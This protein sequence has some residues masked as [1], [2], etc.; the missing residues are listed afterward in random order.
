MSRALVLGGGG[1]TGVAWEL[2]LLAGL[3]ERGVPVTGADLVVGTSAGS[4]VGAQ[5]CSVLPLE[6]FYEEQLVP[7]SSEVAARLGFA[8]LA[9]LVWAGG[10][11]RDV[12]RSRA[13]IGAM[14]VAA[15]TPSEASR[16]A[17]I[18]ARLP[19]RE[20][21]AR[22]L[23]ITAVDASSGEFVVFDRDSEV[24]LVDAVGA[25]CAV[26]GVWP[27]VTVGARRYV[28]GG[29]RSSVNA[30]LAAGAR[31]VL[32]F[33]PTSAAFGPMPRLSAQVA[34]LR[35]A[36][37]RVVV[38]TPDAAARAAIGRNVLDPARRAGAA[39]AGR[40]QAAVVVDEVAALWA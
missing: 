31:R 14:A 2:G 28:D 15:R 17:V 23:L 30:D 4:V 26:P 19:A 34:E 10:R 21:P 40:A 25:S 1:V 32:V 18:E 3:V 5:V 11:T 37:S 7:P 38:V 12:V 9:R 27:P 33:A 8:T 35:V 24:S 36:G 16:R 6:Q 39:R 22:R 13:R 20:W 29:M